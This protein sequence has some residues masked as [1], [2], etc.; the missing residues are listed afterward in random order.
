MKPVLTG[1]SAEKSKEGDAQSQ[2]AMLTTYAYDQYAHSRDQGFHQGSKRSQF[3]KGV[4]QRNENSAEVSIAQLAGMSQK[5]VLAPTSISVA[6]N[7]RDTL[8]TRSMDHTPSDNRGTLRTSDTHTMSMHHRGD[9][10]RSSNKSQTKRHI[11]KGDRDV[12]ISSIK[13]LDKRATDLPDHMLRPVQK[14]QV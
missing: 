9:L 3:R 13:V 11:R 1:N 8:P 6:E 7:A 10:A 14:Q 12:G 4:M 2:G 5:H